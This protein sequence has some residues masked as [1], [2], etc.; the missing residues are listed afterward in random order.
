M[1]SIYVG[2]YAKYNAGS[3]NGAHLDIEDYNCKDEFINAC[4]ELHADEDDP[5]LMFQDWEGIPSCF[6]S[7]CHVDEKLWDYLDCNED[8]GAKEA[9]C[10]LFGRWDGEDTFRDRYIG[11]FDSRYD[12]AAYFIDEC[13]LLTDAHEELRYYFD[14]D[15]YGRDMILG[16]DVREENGYYFYN[17]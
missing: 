7:E 9:Y 3:L 14:Y 12:L 10:E 2:T 1:P 11:E 4:L 6:I 8:D 5:E 13:G 16:G 17:N 15:A